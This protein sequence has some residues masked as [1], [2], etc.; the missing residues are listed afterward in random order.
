MGSL[1]LAFLIGFVP[2]VILAV[3]VLVRPHATHRSSRS[4][5]GML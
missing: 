5:R 2:L 4:R 1:T 3:I